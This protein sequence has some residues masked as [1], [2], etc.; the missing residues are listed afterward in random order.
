MLGAGRC[1][2]GDGG[3]VM[4]P[5]ATGAA[6]AASRGRA[7]LLP[8]LP[9]LPLR[10]L[11]RAHGLAPSEVAV[12]SSGSSGAGMRCGFFRRQA[13]NLA[14]RGA[15]PRAG[16]SSSGAGR[17]WRCSRVAGTRKEPHRG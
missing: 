15:A 2:D 14:T 10:T 11:C 9:L 4:L 5:V 1:R 7:A 8:V 16:S 17:A 12:A 3:N 6:T 13:A